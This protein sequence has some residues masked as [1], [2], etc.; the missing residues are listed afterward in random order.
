[1]NLLISL[2]WTGLA[3]V[4][5]LICTINL[6]YWI[7]KSIQLREKFE[8]I[9]KSLLY[10][11]WM[12]IIVFTIASGLIFAECILAIINEVDFSSEFEQDDIQ[13]MLLIAIAFYLIGKYLVY[14]IL[15]LR[16]FYT[17]DN[18]A[19]SYQ[20][21][22]YKIVKYSIFFEIFLGII[23]VIAFTTADDDNDFVAVVIGG[24]YFILDIIIPVTLNVCVVM[25]VCACVL[26][27]VC[28][29]ACLQLIWWLLLQCTLKIAM[30]FDFLLKKRNVFQPLLQAQFCFF[31]TSIVSVVLF[32][33]LLCVFTNV[34]S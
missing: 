16:L 20:A 27:F 17:L 10:L 12:A 8:Q 31:V 28:L 29:L 23:A 14:F 26:L 15:Y 21:K 32:M 3:C 2:G 34:I 33:H 4:P 24:I 13:L 11:N 22:T 1:M 25:C 5:F 7:Y 18:S 6:F 19:Y 30:W 9:T